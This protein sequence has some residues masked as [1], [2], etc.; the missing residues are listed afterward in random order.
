[1]ERYLY[2]QSASVLMTFRRTE[3]REVASARKYL[4]GI[5]AHKYLGTLFVKR[6]M[7][8]IRFV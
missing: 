7:F 8:R 2:V 6:E 4:F 1:M 3:V 5:S